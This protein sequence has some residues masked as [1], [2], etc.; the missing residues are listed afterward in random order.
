MPKEG[1]KPAVIVNMYDGVYC[2]LRVHLS[3]RYDGDDSY[4]V[5][6]HYSKNPVP[7]EAVVYESRASAERALER[8]RAKYYQHSL[9]VVD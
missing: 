8:L 2:G 5:L 1:R 6:P 9:A 4:V 3:N 7:G